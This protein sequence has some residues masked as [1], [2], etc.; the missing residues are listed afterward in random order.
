[1]PW[2]LFYLWSFKAQPVYMTPPVYVAPPAYVVPVTRPPVVITTSADCVYS[3]KGVY[4]H[5]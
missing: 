5:C 3:A 1:M 2:F 4:S